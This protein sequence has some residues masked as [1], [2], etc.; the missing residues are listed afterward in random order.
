MLRLYF[1]LVRQAAT[2]FIEDGA[3]SRGAAIAYYTVTSI[4]PVLLIVVAIAGFVFGE[5]AAR[6]AIVDELGS[7][8]GGKSADLLQGMIQNASNRSTGT[9]ATIIGGVTLLITASGV[10]GE[11]QAALNAIWKT[12]PASAGAVSRLVRARLA[13]LGLVATMGFLLLV[14][15]VLSAALQALGGWLNGQLPGLGIV[16]RVLNFLVSLLLTSVLF[17]A[18]YKILPD[19]DLKWPDVIVGAVTT[20]VLFTLGKFL[21]SLYIGSSSIASTYGAA[22]SLIVVLIWVYYSAQIFLLGA[23]FTKAYASSQGSFAAAPSESGHA[24]LGE[25]RQQLGTIRKKR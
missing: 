7:L 21:I 9:I 5:E 3:L 18:V 1:G 23:E 4:A 25:L 24:R 11:M 16:L 22:G 12:E 20:A 19:V 10:F 15:L 14:S 2:Q 6:G 8:M 13:S 17:G